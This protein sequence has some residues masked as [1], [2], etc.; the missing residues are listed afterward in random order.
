MYSLATQ[1]T[2]GAPPSLCS[3]SDY[4]YETKLAVPTGYIDIA[5]GGTGWGPEGSIWNI[6]TGAG[7][8]LTD[9]KAECQG[10]ACTG[11]SGNKDNSGKMIRRPDGSWFMNVTADMQSSLMISGLLLADTTG[12]STG[13][14]NTYPLDV[15]AVPPCGLPVAENCT[16]RNF[17]PDPQQWEAYQVDSFL[18]SYLS[19]HDINSFEALVNQAQSDFEPKMDANGKTCD[20][21]NSNFNC[22]PPLNIECSSDPTA[23]EIRGVIMTTAIVEFVNFMST[24]YQSVSTVSGS[25]GSE[26]DAITSN[27]WVPAA[28]ETWTEIMSVLS[29]VIGLMIAGFVILD[30]VTDAAFTPFLV[31]G[32]IVASNAFGLAGNAGNLANPSDTDTEFEQNSKYETGAQNM[33]S[34]VM[35]GFDVLIKTNETGQ[36]G[37]SK[38]IGGGAW[39]GS[40]VKSFFNTDGIGANITGWYEELMIAQFITK[41][42]TDNDAYILFLPYGDNVPYNGK[43]WGFNQ[44]MCED[45]WT[46]DPSWNYYAACDITFGPSGPPGMSV[47]TR[48]SS[49]G[50]S[51]DSWV[52]PL[53]YKGKNITGWDIMASSIWGQQQHGFNFT[54]LSDN[55]T[56]IVSQGG[57]SAVSSIFSNVAIDQP[58]LYNV[59]V[60]LVKDL[61]YMPGVDQVMS[62]TDNNEGVDGYYH[63]DD[64]C[65]CATY[66]YTSP[67]GNTGNFTDFVSSKVQDSI[68]GDC[69][70]SGDM[71]SPDDV[72]Y[73]YGY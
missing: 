13:G 31:A 65:T 41:A 72:S 63:A 36:T 14:N 32:S 15:V 43:A 49:E 64:P 51:S 71:R 66:G 58:G 57:L 3:A 55:F 21:T 16:S 42:L 10:S 34:Q 69:S 44:T 68:S 25:I 27:F 62:D 5:G 33:L 9:M 35:N 30:A 24:L 40:G 47:F 61:V 12:Q 60:C 26:L 59:P 48:P 56:S 37:I 18:K 1:F 50:S 22:E 8:K 52:K 29:S 53:S 67:D 19:K 20:I 39:V 73:G 28:T 2:V 54:Y 17:T 46:N 23:D 45:H 6:S 7:A 4:S 11:I 70:V 38:V